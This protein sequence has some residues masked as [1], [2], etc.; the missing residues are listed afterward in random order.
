MENVNLIGLKSQLEDL[1]M[2]I[3]RYERKAR[4]A[5]SPTAE[6]RYL[7]LVAMYSQKCSTLR[8]MIISKEAEIQGLTEW[9]K[10]KFEAVR[11]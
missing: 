4:K 7:G 10:L 5:Q 6:K 2:L 9:G 1:K 8:D 3:K 11:N